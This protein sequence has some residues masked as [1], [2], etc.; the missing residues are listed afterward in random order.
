MDSFE[1]KIIIKNM[2]SIENFWFEK[3]SIITKNVIKLITS[4]MLKCNFKIDVM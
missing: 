4:C 1:L 2:N 3:V